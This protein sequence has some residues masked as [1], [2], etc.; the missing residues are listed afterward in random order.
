MTDTTA[1][2]AWMQEWKD[3]FV[4]DEAVIEELIQAMIRKRVVIEQ[5][6]SKKHPGE[7]VRS[8][9][10]VLGHSVDRIYSEDGARQACRVLFVGGD[11][12][13]YFI[14]KGCV[15]TIP[16]DDGDDLRFDFREDAE[17]S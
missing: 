8:E 4:T 2:D 7:L 16:N 12:I 11:G 3:N 6:A 17:A 13:G 15:V 1:H 5:H 14:R 10:V 9:I